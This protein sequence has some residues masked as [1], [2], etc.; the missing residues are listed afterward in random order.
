MSKVFPKDTVFPF[1]EDFLKSG[2]IFR[3]EGDFSL[4][5]NHFQTLLESKNPEKYKL[6]F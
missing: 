1:E 3:C 4:V 6:Y 5:E 2:S